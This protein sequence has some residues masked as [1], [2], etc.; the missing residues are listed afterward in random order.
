MDVKSTYKYARISARK[1]RDV[2]REIQGLPVSEALDIL[3]FTPRKAAELFNKTMKTALADAENNFELAVEGLFVKSAVVGEGP[4]LKRFKPRAR[5]SAS[6]IRKR[7]S[8]LT[9][10]LS[11]EPGRVADPEP[12]ASKAAARAKSDAKPAPQA[13]TAEAA[14]TESSE[15][16]EEK[17]PADARALDL[18]LGRV[19]DSAPPEVDDLTE[20][21][22]VGPVLEEKLHSFGV[23]TFQQIA[24]WNEENIAAFDELLDFKGRIERDG[25]VAK[26][27]ALHEEK[28]GA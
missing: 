8:H 23:Y 14:P 21:S 20:I 13:K 24:E 7:T 17:A 2:A 25:W 11:D 6:S 4:T 27:K 5:G 26:A 1:A 22:G 9:V 19:Y 16:G 10:I 28:H 15:K 12:K 3:A 18:D